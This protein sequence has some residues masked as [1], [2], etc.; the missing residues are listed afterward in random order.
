MEANRVMAENTVKR[1]VKI[2]LSDDLFGFTKKMQ[3]GEK[4]QINAVVTVASERMD[5]GTKNVKKTLR[6]VTAKLNKNTRV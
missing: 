2:W 6:M 1:R 5:E 4:G 3:V